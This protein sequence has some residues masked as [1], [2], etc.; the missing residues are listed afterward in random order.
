MGDGARGASDGKGRRRA[1]TA[2]VGAQVALALIILNCAALFGRSFAALQHVRPGFQPDSVLTAYMT[3]P[4]RAYDSGYKMVRLYEQ[5]QTSTA[6]L[7]GVKQASAIY[8]LPMSGEPWSGSFAIEGARPDAEPPHAE[9]AVTLPEYFHVMRI[10]ILQG[11]DFTRA[12]SKDAPLVVVVDE[13]LARKYWPREN[14]IGKRINA[15]SPEG[16]WATVVG[17]VGHVHSLGPQQTSGPQLYTPF[18]QSPQPMLYTVMRTVVAPASLMGGLRQAVGSLDRDLAVSKLRTMDAVVATTTARPRFNLLMLTIFAA[19]A[20]TLAAVGLYGVMSYLVAQ[21][22]RE[23]GIRIALGGRP[24]AVRMTIIRQSFTIALVGLAI[25]T[26]TTLGIS[27]LLSRLLFGVKG[28]DPVSYLVVS[29]LLLT[30]TIVASY[31][32]AQ[33]ATRIDPILALRG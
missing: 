2:L 14:P 5:L 21:R 27:G 22:T 1:R 15:L 18:A 29:A 10:P 11:R 24:S 20:L 25:G 23:I 16:T 9:L 33:R 32:P 13:E 8:P 6:T 7:P 12:D 30:V 31:L 19:V 17:V 26:V 4:R 28:T 3:L